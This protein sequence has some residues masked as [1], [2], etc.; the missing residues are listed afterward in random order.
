MFDTEGNIRNSIKAII[1]ENNK[2]LLTKNKYN[3]EEF[4]LLPGGGQRK[5]ETIEET[6]KREC[7]EEVGAEIEII[8]LLFIREYI[9]KNHQFSIEDKNIHQVE[10][11]FECKLIND[12]LYLTENKDDF[13]IGYEW[14]ELSDLKNILL[15]PDK[16]KEVIDENGEFSKEI[17]LGDIN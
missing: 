11:M 5:F 2:I 8:K 12:E 16:L 3:G 9:G 14:I 4:Y 1:I 13:Q 17:Y 6:L 7:F 10:L 15:Y